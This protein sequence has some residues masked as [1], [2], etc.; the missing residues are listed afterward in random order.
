[1]LEYKI[2]VDKNDIEYGEVS[3]WSV[4]LTDGFTSITGFT[5][6]SSF[7]DSDTEIYVEFDKNGKFIKH[8]MS[9]KVVEVNGSASIDVEYIVEDSENGK[10]VRY[11]DGLKHYVEYRNGGGSEDRMCIVVNGR[12][13]LID[14][15]VK[16][17][18]GVDGDFFKSYYGFSE[19]KDVFVINDTI[20]INGNV[21]DVVAD[22]DLMFTVFPVDT[23]KPVIGKIF[24]TRMMR[25]V[26]IYKNEDV[27]L[28]PYLCSNCDKV[29]YFDAP[30]KTPQDDYEDYKRYYLEKG[31]SGYTCIFDDVYGGLEYGECVYGINNVG[32]PEELQKVACCISGD[33]IDRPCFDV[34]GD[35]V[36]CDY[37]TDKV[38]L[39]I[40]EKNA[41][42]RN[43]D[44]VLARKRRSERVEFAILED[45]DEKKY[46]V[47][48][49]K[50]YYEDFGPRRDFLEETIDDGGDYLTI[51]R[52]PIIRETFDKEDRYEGKYFKEGSGIEISVS[53]SGYTVVD[54]KFASRY[55]FK[56]GTTRVGKYV[57]F[58]VG[59]KS[60]YAE[61]GSDILTIEGIEEIALSVEDVEKDGLYVCGIQGE[62]SVSLLKTIVENR[63]DYEFMYINDM[64][65]ISFNDISFFVDSTRINIPI[66]LTVNNSIK[67][68][69][70]DSIS[71][72]VAEK[73]DERINRIVDMERDVYYPAFSG[74]GGVSLI[75]EM[76]FKLHF[77]TR[78]LE[79][80][81]INE[82]YVSVYGRQK[83]DMDSGFTKNALCCNWNIIDYYYDDRN[84]IGAE[85]SQEQAHVTG[86]V[87]SDYYK[88][89]ITKY[90]QP[91]DLLYFL[92]FTDNDI[93]YQKKKV[94]KSFLRLL[95]YD[96][97]DPSSQNLLSTET[98]Y[99]DAD[100]LYRN[101]LE[102]IDPD[103]HDDYGFVNITN[104]EYTEYTG[105]DREPFYKGGD[106]IWTYREDY[107]IDASF[108]VKGWYEDKKSSSGYYL[109]LFKEFSDDIHP[110]DIYM[111]VQFC[112]AGTGRVI[113]FMLPKKYDGQGNEDLVDIT[114]TNERENFKKG[115][116]LS[117]ITNQIYTRLTV[118]YDSNLKKFVYCLPK[119]M[120]NDSEKGRAIFNL[121]EVKL[122]DESN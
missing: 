74:N 96:S 68:N 106:G 46:I 65:P 37:D 16:R 108:N 50:R 23:E 70:E 107:R 82:D 6:I 26:T 57:K 75:N 28:T 35:I 81:K 101:Y 62:S 86:T 13:I 71:S 83:K 110:H 8:A 33:S 119:Y 1:M 20:E 49:G 45:G 47:F 89:N 15:R 112:H 24:D 10:F 38:F 84:G 118:K 94:K 30:S 34:Y 11:S 91:S 116:G 5:D 69:R 97:T 32:N 61:E 66:S 93:L 17:T 120:M 103:T 29:Y 40:S 51:R 90:C 7:S 14:E 63:E 52:Y 22:K 115:Y 80:W 72:F 31:E 44:V 2:K 109:Y 87:E 111:K 18:R 67:V 78:D 48:N 99:F 64:L 85:I 113:N 95:F 79:T 88:E 9:S 76:S 21:Y 4:G 53:G 92:N 43:G 12:V 117:E 55:D 54:D 58:V 25:L 19:K 27:V 121:Y 59:G 41:I 98:M 39:G 60:Y 73:V 114:D 100:G 104:G 77:R 56:E 3:L 36:S 102:N 122:K 42:L 105:V